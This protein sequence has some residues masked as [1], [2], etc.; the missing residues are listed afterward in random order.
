MT[1][2]RKNPETKVVESKD[3][4][5]DEKSGGEG[6][7]EARETIDAGDRHIGR[8]LESEGIFGDVRGTELPPIAETHV[9]PGRENVDSVEVRKMGGNRA[10]RSDT[11]VEDA[12]AGVA[13][14]LS[15]VDSDAALENF[16]GTLG[17]RPEPLKTRLPDDTSSD[18]HTDV[19]PENAAPDHRRKDEAA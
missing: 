2:D 8:T 4:A 15:D 6:R 7:G 5:T 10:D 16:P 13:G 14:D 12:R 3:R 9:S 19:E 1:E 17:S 11:D 18:P